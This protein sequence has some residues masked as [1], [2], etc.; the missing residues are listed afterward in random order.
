[1]DISG[2]AGFRQIRSDLKSPSNPGASRVPEQPLPIAT[3]PQEADHND[4]A[5]RR[6]ASMILSGLRHLP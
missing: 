3:N 6:F 2:L 1:M 4:H 5:Y